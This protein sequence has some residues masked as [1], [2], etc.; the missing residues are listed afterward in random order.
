[1]SNVQSLPGTLDFRLCYLPAPTQARV[2]QWIRAFASGAV[3]N[4]SLNKLV[5]ANK[6]AVILVSLSCTKCTDVS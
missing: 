5:D 4:V 2:A 1:M 6:N 3:F